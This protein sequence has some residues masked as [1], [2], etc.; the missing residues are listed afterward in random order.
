MNTVR[1]RVNGAGQAHMPWKNTGGIKAFSAERLQYPNTVLSCLSNGILLKPKSLYTNLYHKSKITGPSWKDDPCIKPEIAQT[2]KTKRE[3]TETIE[4]TVQPGDTIS[5]IAQDH[6]V[7]VNTILW[8][9]NKSAY[10]IIRPGDSLKI[11]P[12]TGLTHTI[13]K[14]DSITTIAKKYEVEEERLMEV[15]NL[16]A[17]DTLKIGQKLLS[18][19][20]LDWSGYLF[21]STESHKE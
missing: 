9:N 20:P 12:F 10:S 21:M 7:S 1:T 5:T 3:R 15:N 11:L 17:G 6:E 8:E 19:L 2:E 18:H 14:G 13:A 4:Y 16:I